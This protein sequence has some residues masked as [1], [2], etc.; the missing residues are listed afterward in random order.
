MKTLLKKVW[1]TKLVWLYVLTMIVAFTSRYGRITIGYKEPLLVGLLWVVVAFFRLLQKKHR[2]DTALM[3]NL[4]F[5]LC[6]YL[7]PHVITHLYTIALM[8]LGKVEWKYL[9]SNATVYL[10]VLIVLSAVYLFGAKALRYT[11]IAV[12]GAFVLSMVSSVILVGPHIIPD[13]ILQAYFGQ[14]VEKNFLELHDVVLAIGYI[15]VYY[16]YRGR[17]LDRRDI[18]FIVCA[19]SI[20]VLGMKRI[21]V[22]AILVCLAFAALVYILPKKA[23]YAVCVVGGVG[24][25]VGCFG[26]LWLMSKGDLFFNLMEKLHINTMG[27]IYYY[28]DVMALADFHVL[29]PGIG[30]NVVT[31]LL[32]NEMSYL[33]VGGVH[34]D[35]IKMYVENGFVM[36]GLWSSYHLLAFPAL[37]RK[38]FGNST[39]VMGFAVTMYSFLLYLTDNIEIYFVCQ[40]LAMMIPMCFAL[41][42]SSLLNAK[43]KMMIDG[44]KQ[45]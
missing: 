23:R 45:K 34:S 18:A 31:Q 1:S 14:S 2:A 5:F 38:R 7:I 19:V 37:L 33:R 39:A 27:R 28:R 32:Q 44:E 3:K 22:L 9:T 8:L 29:Y 17:K 40:T 21:V 10:P 11:L 43:E 15:M 12:I 41:R 24:I 35:I 30:R 36:Y 25:L 26:F 6:A 42:E 16:L 4:G 13:A 20:G